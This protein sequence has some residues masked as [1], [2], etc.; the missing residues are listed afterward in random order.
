MHNVVIMWEWRKFS[1][2]KLSKSVQCRRGVNNP[3]TSS[4]RYTGNSGIAQING[5][6]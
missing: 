6:K 2:N 3:Q 5:T 4:V 1:N